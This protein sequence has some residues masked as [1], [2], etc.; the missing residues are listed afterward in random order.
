MILLIILALISSSCSTI[1][2]CPLPPRPSLPTLTRDDIS[3]L[4][5]EAL[6]KMYDRDLVLI[7]HIKLLEKEMEKCS[8]E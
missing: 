1:N 4:S 7:D 5:D 3:C 6:H 2:T 8:N